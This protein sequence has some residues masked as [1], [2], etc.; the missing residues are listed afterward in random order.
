LF[1]RASGV[2]STQ[3]QSVRCSIRPVVPGRSCGPGGCS[4]DQELLPQITHQALALPLRAGSDLPEYGPRRRRR[5]LRDSHESAV[6][7][8]SSW[9]TR[10]GATPCNGTDDFATAGSGPTR[11]Y[12]ARDCSVS[13]LWASE[14]HACR[15]EPAS[16]RR[17]QPEGPAASVAK[18]PDTTWSFRGK[19][20][21]ALRLSLQQRVCGTG[22]VCRA[23]QMRTGMAV[24]SAPTDG[25]RLHSLRRQECS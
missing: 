20:R 14:E 1:G 3:A 21:L 23:G 9:R 12:G 2:S 8:R 5:S 19:A 16:G 25:R 17:M 10:A 22:V 13:L 6:G 24:S 4:G 18:L 11:Q 15:C 7:R